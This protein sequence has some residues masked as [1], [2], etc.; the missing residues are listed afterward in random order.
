MQKSEPPKRFQVT[1]LAERI[2]K[3]HGDCVWI[4]LEDSRHDN[5]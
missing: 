1:K 4:C 5:I 2:Q 3:A